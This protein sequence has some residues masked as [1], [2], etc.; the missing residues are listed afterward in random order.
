MKR[1]I[2]STTLVKA[3]KFPH[4]KNFIK[5]ILLSHPRHWGFGE[6]QTHFLAFLVPPWS[7]W[8]IMTCPPLNLQHLAECVQ[9]KTDKI[10]W[11]NEWI[12]GS[13]F[14]NCFIF[15]SSRSLL[16]WSFPRKSQSHLPIPPTPS[17]HHRNSFQFSCS[18]MSDSLWPH[19]LQHAR[20]SC[21]SPTPRACSNSCPLSRWCHPTI[22]SSVIPFSS[23]PQYFPALRSFLR[24]Q[25]KTQ[26]QIPV[27]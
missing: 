13:W 5:A 14:V 7:W 9:H 2:N 3:S 19:G 27:T 26:D 11:I 16:Y 1:R 18:V 23:C 6:Q 22:S 12:R 15:Q 4:L 25:P 20:L 10:C 17:P 24:S 8:R 21:P